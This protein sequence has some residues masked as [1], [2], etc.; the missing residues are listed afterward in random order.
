MPVQYRGTPLAI[1]AVP[2]R[3]VPSVAMAAAT[4]S[5]NKYSL[6][7]VELIT[8]DLNEMYQTA[9]RIRSSSSGK[10]VLHAPVPYVIEIGFEAISEKRVRDAFL[11]IDTNFHL[12]RE[13]VKALISMGCT[14]LKNDPVFRCM[15]ED[16][17]SEAAGKHESRY[18]LATSL[19]VT[20]IPMRLN[21]LFAR[22]Q[23]VGRR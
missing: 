5:M 9:E 6:D 15:L 20:F 3:I 13:Q 22:I 19:E 16:F 21:R 23:A 4:I 17:E 7:S 18:E 12:P 8:K 1:L 14:L 10:L 11:S 2:P